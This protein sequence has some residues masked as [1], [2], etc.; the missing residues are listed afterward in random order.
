LI[1]FVVIQ[2]TK[3]FIFHYFRFFQIVIKKILIYKV[4]KNLDYFYIF[5]AER[6]KNKLKLRFNTRLSVLR[7]SEIYMNLNLNLLT[8]IH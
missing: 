2:S 1:A 4:Y 6:I 8:I 7:E 3:T 5:I